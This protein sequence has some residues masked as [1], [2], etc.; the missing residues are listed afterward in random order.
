MS[1]SV[2]ITP[3]GRLVLER[4]ADLPSS[5]DDAAT[6][7]LASSFNESSAQGLLWLCSAGLSAGLAPALTFWRDFGRR[8]FHDVCHA[9]EEGDV[10]QKWL[11]LAP[12]PEAELLA[13][14]AAAPPMRGLEYLSPELLVRL[15]RELQLLVVQ[16]AASHAGGA[17]GFLQQVNPNWH[18]LGKVTFHLA[19]NKQDAARPF[20]F[21]ATYAR[22]LSQ[23]GRVQHVPLGQALKDYA[24]E[25]NK[26][27]LAALLEPVRGAA[28][29]SPLVRELLDSRSLFQA[30]AW[31]VREAYRFLTE[32][33]R[34]EAAG[35]VVRVPDWWTPRQPPRPQV[36]V[37]LGQKPSSQIGLKGLLDFSVELALDGQPLSAS[38]RRQ[39]LEASDG[40]TLLRGRWVEVNR[41]QL[42]EA[43]D[44]WRRLES[45]HPDGISFVEGM[46]LLAG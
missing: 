12:P 33:P 8:F 46:R 21:L 24:G 27:A 29:E 7:G 41:R 15:W 23:A 39:L 25:K 36:R 28:D 2:T 42:D 17:K 18:L 37:V 3:A 40:L 26:A 45:L 5:L 34:L 13:T 38:E 43:L 14:V 4:A 9:G 19:E 16:K 22:R 1:Y 31:T 11:E 32:A 35:V 30:Q 20:A 10:A 6:E 44:H